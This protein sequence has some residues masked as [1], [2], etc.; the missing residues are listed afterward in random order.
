MFFSEKKQ[1]Y[2][3]FDILFIYEFMALWPSQLHK[4]KYAVLIK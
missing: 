1:S 3:K 4:K 2:R